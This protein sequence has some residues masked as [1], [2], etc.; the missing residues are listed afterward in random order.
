MS[1]QHG[2]RCV[3]CAPMFFPPDPPPRK[4][5]VEEMRALLKLVCLGDTKAAVDLDNQLKNLRG[6]Q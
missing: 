2:C 1:H 6:L 3:E 5:N 4:P